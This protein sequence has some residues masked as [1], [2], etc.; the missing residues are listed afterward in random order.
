MKRITLALPAPYVG[1]RPFDEKDALIFFGRDHH[2]RDLLAKLGNQQRFISVLGASGTGKSSLVR[3]G[4]IPALHRGALA[5]V[6][7]QWKVYTFKPGD[8]PLHNLVHALTED[9][10]W[11]DNNTDRATAEASLCSLLAVSPLALTEQYRQRAEC[12]GNEA[13]L[14]VVD[15]FE[16]IFRY[17]QKNSDEAEAFIQLLLRTAS[18]DVPIYVVMTMRSDFLGNC[19]A[20][21]GLPEAINSG[22]YLTPR[23][24]PDPLKSIIAS[25][26]ALVGGDID[27]VLVTRLINTLGG[28]DE[29]PILE[30][31]LLRMWNHAKD[32]GRNRIDML[33]FEAVC[34]P[35]HSEQAGNAAKVVFTIDNHAS[36]IFA[37][38]TGKQQLLAQQMFLAL[39]ENRDG[40]D[41]RRPQTM[42][43]LTDLLGKDV[44]SD[45]QTILDKFRVEQVGFLLPPF[46]EP[47]HAETQIDISHESLFRQWH[48][49]QQWLKEEA[50]DISELREWQQRALRQHYGGGWLDENDCIRAQRWRDRVHSRTDPQL[51]VT[52]YV[53]ERV[54]SHVDAYI[55][56]SMHRLNQ[57]KI[58]HERLKQ[59]KNEA[60]NR[61]LRVEARNQRETA[62]RAEKE[63]LQAQAFAKASRRRSVI[64]IAAAGVAIIFAILSIGLW[65]HADNEKIRAEKMAR[66]AKAAELIG[67]AENLAKIAP[68]QSLLLALTAR[69]I[70][71]VPKAEAHLRY[72][73]ATFNYRHVLRGHEDKIYTAQFSP[74][75]ETIL[76]TGGDNTVI[77]WNTPTG[78]Q[79][80][81]LSGHEDRVESAQFSPD[82]RTIVSA[83]EDK[84]IRIWNSATGKQLHILHGHEESVY[85]AKFSPDGRVILSVGKDIDMRLWD[86]ATGKQLHILDGHKNYI[87][88]DAQFSPDGRTIVSTS[89]DKTVLWDTANGEQLHV[90]HGHT[91]VSFSPDGKKVLTN[92]SG[93]A[94]LWDVFTGKQL[95]ALPRRGDKNYLL[96]QFSPNGKAILI[97]SRENTASL[98]DTATGKELLILGGHDEPVVRAQ[99]SSDGKTILTE[100]QS[101]SNVR[102]W[103]IAT[104][105]EL[106]VLQGNDRPVADA[107]FFPNG[108]W[109]ITTG[110]YGDLLALI[111]DKN[112]RDSAI[113]VWDVA[114]GMELHVFIGHEHGA[115]NVYISPNGR[116]ILSVG[117]DGDSTARIWNV[118]TENNEF[119]VFG[120]QDKKIYSAQFSP[121]GKTILTIGAEDSTARLWN[122]A[123]G[124]ELLEFGG[125]DKPVTD[126][127]FSPDGKIF[128]TTSMHHPELI[129]GNDRSVRVWSINGKELQVLHDQ[130]QAKFSPDG[131]AIVTFGGKDH[132]VRL[133]DTTSGKELQVF[134]GHE[135][136]IRSAGFSPDGRAIITASYDGTVRL[137]N[138]KTGKQ[139]LTLPVHNPN[140]EAE[141]SP[142]GKNIL[143]STLIPDSVQLR[144]AATAKQRF[145]L[146][147]HNDSILFGE[148]SLNGQIILT[149][150]GDGDRAHLWDASSGEQ[151]NILHEVKAYRYHMHF[152]PD[153]RTIITTDDT[154]IKVR[155]KP[156]IRLWDV[157]TG[158]QLRVIHLEGELVVVDA[159]FSP[160][161]KFILITG[162]GTARLLPCDVCASIEKIETDLRSRVGRELTKDERRR[163]GVPDSVSLEN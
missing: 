84:T 118:P 14:L 53:N 41:V 46:H 134:A 74:D 34:A 119:Q 87:R 117:K 161:G 19:V 61:L 78:K 110:W 162:D 27:L 149:K 24:G 140:V 47:I 66:D 38:L 129:G 120:E 54:F 13:L 9:P 67:V 143:I 30:H 11:I 36:S 83:S 90:L 37:T 68:D 33:D 138:T 45:L 136:S 114:T 1:L 128:L 62:E 2:V 3:A 124:K 42:Q 48:L 26:L 95:Q 108:K 92:R 135:D 112:N 77:L 75:G 157:V 153:G 142:D 6:G 141:F 64:A 50:L 106:H 145:T 131:K 39:V 147:R 137:W 57:A 32:A 152:S 12:F 146:G 98:W 82:G 104:G 35:H 148:F 96:A 10:R 158:K 49:F 121:N 59:E 105:K 80:H 85:S 113:R 72:A 151:L 73:Y 56:T 58:E 163:F 116:T 133:W 130:G 20:F 81:V 160:D 52:R 70:S 97:I 139:I 69:Q 44:H 43:Q 40:R 100:E 60:V 159:K 4:L 29:L 21:F 76:T 115:H 17:R 5:S 101:G 7:F 63:K 51:W 91:Y 88:S 123:T 86:T 156:G 28:D 15:Q 71:N 25:P 155:G 93:T 125:K 126:A 89:N 8:A 150:E 94:Y 111:N 22:L 132:T 23:L 31:A 144:D 99:F 18:E 103:D 16:E 55:E 154:G 107:Q 122:I 102:L 109:I 127:E 65:L 79:L